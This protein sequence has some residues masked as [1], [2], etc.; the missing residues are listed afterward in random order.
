M[1]DGVKKKGL[2]PIIA[3]VLLILLVLVLAS[4][5]F[6]WARGFVGEQIE[7]FGAPIEESC[8]GISFEVA[9]IGN[10]LEVLNKGGVDIR[11]LDVR[12]TKGGTSITKRFDFSIDS[13]DFESGGFSFFMTEDDT[14]VPDEIIVYPAL[15]GKVVG[16]N[17]N[18][19]YTCI[20]SG[21][22]L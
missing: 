7:K 20:N 19:V 5:V 4:I 22:T 2:S 3:S 21:V 18:N 15:I 13:G 1:K 12:M 6:I 16:E 9:K 10:N 14:E 11:H 17:S 8:D